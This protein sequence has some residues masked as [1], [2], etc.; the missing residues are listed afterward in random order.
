MFAVVYKGVQILH[1][2][3][4]G[5]DLSWSIGS[6][7]FSASGISSKDMLNDDIRVSLSNNEFSSDTSCR[8]SMNSSAT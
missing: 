7:G 5:D 2:G 8:S 6:G 3:Y 1:M 4:D